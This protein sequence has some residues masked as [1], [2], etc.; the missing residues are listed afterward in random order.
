MSGLLGFKIHFKGRFSRKQRATS[1][2]FNEGLLPLTTLSANIDYSFNSIT[3]QNSLISI[4][5]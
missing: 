1:L 2:W 4:K 5:V 3:L